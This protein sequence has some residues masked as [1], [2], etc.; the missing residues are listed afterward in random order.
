MNIKALSLSLS[1]IALL[2]MV[3]SAWGQL[4]RPLEPNV[5]GT[6]G[7]TCQTQWVGG[8]WESC[9]SRPCEVTGNMP[10][11]FCV[12]APRTPLQCGLRRGE[13]W[14][15]GDTTPL[16]WHDCWSSDQCCYTY[17]FVAQAGRAYFVKAQN[18]S[19]FH[20]CGPTKSRL[21]S[22]TSQCTAD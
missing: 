17:N 16:A 21:R 5:P 8:H 13:L 7:A 3:G 14:Q 6:W 19:P 4:M 10:A 1:V 20:E 12:T 11:T 2:A 9:T 18:E 15:S 22:G